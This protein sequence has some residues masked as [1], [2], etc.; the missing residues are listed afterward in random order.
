MAQRKQNIKLLVIL[1]GAGELPQI[2]LQ[3]A[4]S[5]GLQPLVYL[6]SGGEAQRTRLLEI[7]RQH[8]IDGT[9]LIKE[10]SAAR[11]GALIKALKKD[12][13]SHMIILGKI[14]KK[15]VF[16]EGVFDATTLKLIAQARDLG[17]ATIF[18]IVAREVEK[19]GVKLLEQRYFLATLLLSPGVYSRKKP[20]REEQ[21][22][23]EYGMQY[24]RKMGD[25]DIGQT[26]VA[27]Q[28]MI[29]AVEAVEGTDEAIRRGGELA[30]KKKAIVCK[31]QRKR[32]DPRFDIPTV[33]LDTIAV[34]KESGCRGLAIEAEKTFVVNPEAFIKEIN[35]QG[36]IFAVV[37]IP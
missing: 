33:G 13:A 4:L 15:K 8:N 20:G 29:L 35:R 12:G 21:E 27:G 14:E 31:A 11:V 2:A 10:I 32:Q 9:K 34:M 24:A 16:R 26:I 23:I 30:G 18:S 28:K 7:Y 17:D 3:E 25:L 6:A 37:K 19:T 1:A 22:I 36:L 5:Q